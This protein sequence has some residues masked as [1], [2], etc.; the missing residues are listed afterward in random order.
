MAPAISMDTQSERLIQ[1][2]TDSLSGK[3]TILVIAHRLSTNRNA[4]YIYA[5]DD[6]KAI[7]EGPYHE[8]TNKSGSQLGKMV[9]EQVL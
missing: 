6:G 9:L 5:L 4:D 1:E 8:L 3:M 2:S 7:E